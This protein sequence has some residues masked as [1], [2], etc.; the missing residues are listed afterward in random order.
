MRP[1][2][3]PGMTRLAIVSE[4]RLRPEVQTRQVAVLL[5]PVGGLG[6]VAAG[7]DVWQWAVF[8]HQ[9]RCLTDSTVPS[10]CSSDQ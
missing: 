2:Q 10:D 1:P 3:A 8:S 4:N 7:W 6:R 5:H 9:V